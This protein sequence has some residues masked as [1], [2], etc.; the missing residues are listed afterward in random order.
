MNIMKSK[1]VKPLIC[2]LTLVAC[3]FA[4]GQQQKKKPT[5]K[6]TDSNA[7]E[8]IVYRHFF[9]QV[10][11]LKSLG[12]HKKE[13]GLSDDQAAAVLQIAAECERDIERQD[14]KA[15]QV[16][17]AFKATL[18][19]I[20]PGDPVPPPPPILQKL[21]E[22]RDAII[23]HARDRLPVALGEEKYKQLDKVA[24]RNLRITT[25]TLP[26]IESKSK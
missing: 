13:S 20:K 8:L 18:E 15:Q 12:P 7:N 1:H 22:E 23:M 25:L 3:I 16:I 14:M 5:P 21:Q 26:Q 10:V 6:E 19:K 9:H 17:E 4:L 11:L 24:H 2:A